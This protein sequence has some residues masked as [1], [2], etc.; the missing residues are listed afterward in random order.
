MDST[1]LTIV[2]C[3][4]I[5]PFENNSQRQLFELARENGVFFLNPQ[6][7]LASIVQFSLQPFESHEEKF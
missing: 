1:I 5:L 4:N 6:W 3:N 7:V 2:L